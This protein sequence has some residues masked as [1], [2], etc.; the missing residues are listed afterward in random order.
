MSEVNVDVVCLHALHV[1][2]SFFVQ[3]PERKKRR[4][5]GNNTDQP[6]PKGGTFQRRQ[7]ASAPTTPATHNN[8]FVIPTPTKRSRAGGESLALRQ[9]NVNMTPESQRPT[10]T[11]RRP[12]VSTPIV[13]RSKN[14]RRSKS[15]DAINSLS[16]TSL[17]RIILLVS[18]ATF[19]HSMPLV[20]VREPH[21]WG[22]N[23]MHSTRFIFGFFDSY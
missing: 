22:P 4:V 13:E 16:E 12:S 11:N 18:V 2:F 6:R 17:K 20:E 3:T 5:A 10:S 23:S 21:V 8:T 14:H 7:S 9:L 1:K 15:L 19:L